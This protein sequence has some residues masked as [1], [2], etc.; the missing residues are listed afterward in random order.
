MN[1][2]DDKLKPFFDAVVNVVVRKKVNLHHPEDECFEDKCSWCLPQHSWSIFLALVT[3]FW[4]D[5]PEVS[6]GRKAL[7][8][9]CGF[10]FDPDELHDI[11]LGVFVSG[12]G[13]YS[14]E[15][16]DWSREVEISPK[17]PE[18]ARS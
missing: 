13:A 8:R 12:D 17:P 9:N 2:S 10:G 11:L 3:L 4:K 5:A 14:K 16:L 1:I 7:A 18:N 15:F 6:E